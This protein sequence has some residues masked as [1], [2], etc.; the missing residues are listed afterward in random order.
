MRKRSL[1]PREHGAYF[2]LALPLLAACLVRV[3]TPAMLA[4][5]AAACLLFLANEPAR[6]LAGMRG[7]RMQ[8]NDGGRA[9]TRLLV[10]VI[11]GI[12]AAIAGVALSDWAVWEA[13]GL[14]VVAT[15][16]VGVCAWRGIVTTVW[17]E[18]AAE[19][20]LT[21][22]SLPVLVAGGMSLERAALVWAGWAVG[23]GTTVV[24]VRRVIERH[25]QPASWIDAVLALG[26]VGGGVAA[27]FYGLFAVPLVVAALAFVAVPPKA[28]H[29]RAVGIAIATIGL[30]S[31]AVLVRFQ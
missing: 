16:L 26:I 8:E 19:V 27:W 28:T 1:W 17:G 23:F 6:V 20:A 13:C 12:A 3:P 31:V 2:Q 11:P 7:S 15:G 30:V 10:L 25:K 14:V 22:A 24:S 18:L 21:G 29:L 5:T 9:R 4:L